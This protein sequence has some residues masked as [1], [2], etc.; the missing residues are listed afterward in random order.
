[1]NKKRISSCDVSEVNVLP[2]A[3]L[4]VLLCILWLGSKQ[5]QFFFISRKFPPEFIAIRN[6]ETLR[7]VRKNITQ[8]E[9]LCSCGKFSSRTASRHLKMRKIFRVG[10]PWNWN[11]PARIRFC[12]LLRPFSFAWCSCLSDLLLIASSTSPP[13]CRQQKLIFD[14]WS[15]ASR[16][17]S[18]TS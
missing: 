17:A 16:K 2:G 15:L 12:C 6:F 3:A 8:S 18:I 11:G 4:V 9:I 14:C 7:R 1:M 13:F 10:Q 5:K